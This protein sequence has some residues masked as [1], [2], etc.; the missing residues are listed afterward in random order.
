MNFL[1]FRDFFLIFFIFLNFSEFKIDL[2][3]LNK[4]LFSLQHMECLI[5]QLIATIDRHL[6]GGYVAQFYSSVNHYKMI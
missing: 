1:I 6:R 4:I 2:F 3:D 5:A